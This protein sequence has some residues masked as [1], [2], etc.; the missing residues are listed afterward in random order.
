MNILSGI[1]LFYFKNG[2]ISRVKKVVFILQ[3][4][5]EAQGA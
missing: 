4:G 3:G 1:Y 2:F 5:T